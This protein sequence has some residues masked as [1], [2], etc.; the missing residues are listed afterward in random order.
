LCLPIEFA[1]PIL[2]QLPKVLK[3]S[4]LLPRN[5]WCLIRPSRLTN[6]LSEVRQDLWLDVDRERSDMQGCFH[7]RSYRIASIVACGLTRIRLPAA[8]YFCLH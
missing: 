5:A 3:V 8:I 7:C 6:S 4:P 2:K 1:G